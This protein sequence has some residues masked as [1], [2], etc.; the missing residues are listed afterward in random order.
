ML[1]ERLVRTREMNNRA[2][3]LLSTFL[4]ESPCAI[5]RELMEEMGTSLPDET[6]YTALLAGFCGLDPDS[7]ADMELEGAYIRPA[8][9]RLDPSVYRKDPYYMNICIPQARFGNWELTRTV[10]RPYEAFIWRDIIVTGDLKEIPQVGFFDEEFAFP[11][12]H[13]D[14]REWMAVKPDEIE[15]MREAVAAAKGRVAVFGLGIGYYAYMVSLKKGVTEITVVERDPHV[16]SLF[17]EHILPQ[18][19]EKEKIRIVQA[20]AFEFMDGM[21]KDH[22]DTAFTDLW[23]DTSDGLSLYL[24][25]RR[26]AGGLKDTEFIY[27]IEESLLSALRWQLFDTITAKAAS[28]DEAKRMLLSLK[29]AGF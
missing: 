2:A 10:Y 21:H 8:V 29:T 3:W 27:W 20:D 15:T 4:N 18:F 12:V 7:E 24:K 9:R 22:Y 14:G 17:R 23:H 19:S 5:T 13:Q 6:V 1:M 28:Y 25:A 26:K 11:A 16:I